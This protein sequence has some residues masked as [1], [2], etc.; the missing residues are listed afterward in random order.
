[1]HLGNLLQSEGGIAVA[2]PVQIVPVRRRVA[3]QPPGPSAPP[4]AGLPARD[5]AA[6]AAAAAVLG[7]GG[8]TSRGH[9]AAAAVAATAAT[10]ASRAA[11]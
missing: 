1:M 2:G 11:R 8:V 6:A 9:V 10:E 4:S 5:P 3:A 7:L